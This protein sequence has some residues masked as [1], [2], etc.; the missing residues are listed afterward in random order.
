[1]SSPVIAT[2]KPPAIARIPPT[3]FPP[4]N[5]LYKKK[6]SLLRSLV[7]EIYVLETIQDP[8]FW[9]KQN[10]AGMQTDN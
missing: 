3:E 10:Q 9:R 2:S 4:K 6:L 8:K 5:P 1:M 7:R